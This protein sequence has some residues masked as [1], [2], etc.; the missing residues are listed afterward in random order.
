MLSRRLPSDRLPNRLTQAIDLLRRE[1][2]PFI[3]LTESNP[4]RAGFTYPT[5]LLND[6]SH[7]E[8]LQYD[9]QPFGLA[10]A[11][12]AIARDYGRRGITVDPS[13]I[14]LTTST[15]ESYSW[16]F[17]LLCNAGDHVL[18]PRPSYPLFDYLTKLEAVHAKP[19]DLDYDRHWT[20]NMAS[21]EKAVTPQTRALVVVSPN[22][23]TGSFITRE[24][25]FQLMQFCKSHDLA[26]IAD[27][28][29]VDYPLD[30]R[31]ER[32]TDLALQETTLAFSLG[33]L[34]KSIGLPQAKLGWMLLGGPPSL[35]ATALDAL[36][37]IA[38]SYLSVSTS[39]QIAAPN[40]LTRGALIRQEIHSR[41]QGN[42]KTIYH[43][44]SQQPSCQALVVEGGWYAVL[45][46]PA[47]QPEEDLVLDLLQREHVLVYPGYFFDFSN[48]AYLVISLLPPPEVLNDAL[49]R[50]LTVASN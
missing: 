48:E 33:G 6:F 8:A 19:Y 25:H 15:S 5:D 26:L 1:H 39:V 36:E 31:K 24:E 47:T 50:L 22:N 27:E 21:L 4:T 23:P 29:F 3:D 49:P 46:V 18:V 32:A 38:D 30:E 20:I 44:V 13:R 2:Q 9:P 41:I 11:R 14:V 37:L 17:K 45:R 35:C 43:E 42:L 10:C 28:V 34:S 7:V 40:L 16:L 12:E